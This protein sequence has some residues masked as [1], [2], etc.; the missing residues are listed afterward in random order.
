MANPAPSP[1]A[2]VQFVSVY[3]MMRLVGAIG[4]ET[5]LADLAAYIEADFKRWPKFDKTPLV[6]SH[7]D[8][9]VIELMPAADGQNYGFKYVNGHPKNM[10][11]GYQTV[12]AFGVLSDVSN[13]YPIL[14]T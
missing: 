13:G 10:R 9:G 14:L 6:A 12:T 5:V 3:N 7:S 1:L 4:I 8:E 11:E 2:Y